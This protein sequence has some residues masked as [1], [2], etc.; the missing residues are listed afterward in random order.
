MG[1][2]LQKITHNFLWM[3]LIAFFVLVGGVLLGDP[4]YIRAVVI[5]FLLSFIFVGSNFFVIKHIKAEK[6]SDFMTRFYL[7]F[8]GRF[9]LVLAALVAVLM[10]TKIHEIYFTVSFIISYIFHSVI[11]VILIN[12]LLETDN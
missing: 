5:G 2:E 9:V 10:I 12:K 7:S 11:E 3:S 8:G 1:I 4:Q 6:S